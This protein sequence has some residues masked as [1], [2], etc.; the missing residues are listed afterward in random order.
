MLVPQVRHVDDPAGEYVPLEQGTQCI[1]DV[2]EPVAQNEHSDIEAAPTSG[3]YFPPGQA[4]QFDDVVIRL[5]GIVGA[6]VVLRAAV[7]FGDDEE[8]SGVVVGAG[9]MLDDVVANDIVLEV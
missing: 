5:S 2:V 6:P 4:T 1:G 3:R 7:E 8:L 9:V